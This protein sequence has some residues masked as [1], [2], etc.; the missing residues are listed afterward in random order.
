VYVRHEDKGGQNV[1]IDASFLVNEAISPEFP[2]MLFS[3]SDDP[4]TVACLF[5][6]P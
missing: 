4:L 5:V 2:K 1:F 3:K 6:K